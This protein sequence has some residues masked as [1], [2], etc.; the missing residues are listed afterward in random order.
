M[1][2]LLLQLAIIFDAGVINFVANIQPSE[3]M[4]RGERECLSCDLLR[5]L[6]AL[7]VIVLKGDAPGRKEHENRIDYRH[8]VKGP[9]TRSPKV[10]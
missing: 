6:T 5:I 9:I 10:I 2:I 1:M 8:E 4:C 3:S 7:F